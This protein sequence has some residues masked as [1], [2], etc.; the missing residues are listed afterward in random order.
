[1]K[2]Y[3]RSSH[4]RWEVEIQE[5]ADGEYRV[6]ETGGEHEAHFADVDRQGQYLLR[7]GSRTYA[8]SIDEHDAT[9]LMVTIAGE[10]FQLRAF[11]ERERAA[12]KVAGGGRPRTEVV[13][14]SMP[15]VVVELR[16]APGDNL[17]P[18]QAALVLEA[19]KMQ[20]EIA[21]THGGV[22]R[23]ILIEAGQA[24]AAG[25]PLLRLDV[26]PADESPAG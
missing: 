2:Y 16:C 4:D 19:M 7:L 18:G 9:H 8:V 5:R 21:A 11:D 15:G 23:E 17:A 26:P 24:V 12:R 3:L 6:V 22:V 20:N 13:R 1:M 10:S 14:A 25:Q